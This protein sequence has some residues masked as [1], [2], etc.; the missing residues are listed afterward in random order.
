MDWTRSIDIYCER[1]DA[2]FW[3]E[4]WNAVTNAAFIIAAIVAFVVGRRE[5]RL[6]GGILLLITITV[7][8][9]I[10]S[11][12][13]HTFATV[14]AV[15]AD[16]IPIQIF[17]VVYFTLAMRRFVLLPWWAAIVA[18]AAFLAV[19][20]GGEAVM[21]RLFAGALNGSEGY[22]PPLL[23]LVAVGVGLVRWGNAGAGWSLLLASAIFAASLFFR[24]ID[25]AVCPNL[26]IGTHILWHTLNGV[27]LGTLMVAMIRHGAR[28][29]TAPGHDAAEGR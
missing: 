18:T 1:L 16:V 13:F 4:P 20:F 29:G 23:A 27:L 24:T 9:G 15:M 28:P 3:S 17:I 2:S 10:G 19:S 7:L 6:D 11:F 14:W 21:E 25:M 8:V 12:L 5:G 26:P 22:V